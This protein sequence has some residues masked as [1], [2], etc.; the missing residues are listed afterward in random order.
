[1][2]AS[3]TTRGF[4]DATI[5]GDNMPADAV[6][7]TTEEHAALLE[8]QSIGQVIF[9]GDDGH[10]FLADPPTPT[11][12]QLQAQI[13]TEA[14]TYLAST[15]WYVIRWQ[16]NGTPIPDDIATARTEARANV[17]EV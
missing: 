13:N 7:I 8:G 1:M 17:I 14:R 9:W 5:H 16:E 2:F 10:P 11:A 6:V 15:D 12:E 4:Y 3:K